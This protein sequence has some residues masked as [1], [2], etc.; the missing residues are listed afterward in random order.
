MGGAGLAFPAGICSLTTAFTRFAMLF[1]TPQNTF[2]CWLDFLDLQE[3]QYHRCLTAEKRNEYSH[4]VAIHIDITDRTNKFSERAI[5]D[6]HA[7]AFSE[8]NLSLRLIRLFCYLLENT[9][10]LVF[11]QRNGTC[12][13]ADKA[14]DTWRIAHNI[15]GFI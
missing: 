3:I 7:L 1:Q 11:L 9:F 14:C 15:P 5:D 2:M 4:F 12:T 10:D 8:T 13:R 6:A